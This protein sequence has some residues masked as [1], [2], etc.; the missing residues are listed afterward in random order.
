[1]VPATKAAGPTPIPQ[2]EIAPLWIESSD[3]LLALWQEAPERE[4]ERHR[5]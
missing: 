2:F 5:D 3:E 4:R 1:M